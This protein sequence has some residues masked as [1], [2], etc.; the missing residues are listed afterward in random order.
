[1]SQT[2]NLQRRALLGRLAVAVSLAPVAAARG[3]DEALLQETD[4]S[5]IIVHYV[6]D[7]AKAKD[8][9]PGANC[10]N[11]ILYKGAP[12]SAQGP[13]K[14]FEKRLVKAS[15]WCSSWSDL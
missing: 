4:A 10:A 14:L 6:E 3:A 1:M 13:C 7:A 9:Q 2:T 12:D 11:C 15:G 5:A 8:A